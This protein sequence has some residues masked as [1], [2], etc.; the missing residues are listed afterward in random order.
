MNN[1]VLR[2]I[3]RFVLLV[4]LQVLVLNNVYLGPYVMPALYVLFV[5]MLPTSMGR[6]PMLLC[7]FGTGLVVDMMGNVLGFH[8]L[9]CLVLAMGRIMFANRILTHGEPIEVETPSIFSVS[10]QRFIGYLLLMLALFYLVF[11]TIDQFGFRSFGGVLLS[12]V[13]STLVTTLMAVLYQFIFKM[14]D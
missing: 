2:N 4:L 1:L 5:L 14:K 8:A 13:C 11:F 7:A 3:G 9:S 12:V 10:T 6:I